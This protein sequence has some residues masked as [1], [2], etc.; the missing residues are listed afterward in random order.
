[1]LVL[2]LGGPGFNSQYHQKKK[3]V[4]L[5]NYIFSCHF[6]FG[7]HDHV[8]HVYSH[9]AVKKNYGDLPSRS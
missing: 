8:P 7:C 1:M 3:N 5:P 6:F 2:N 4:V 9:G